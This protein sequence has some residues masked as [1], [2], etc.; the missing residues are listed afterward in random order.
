MITVENFI[1]GQFQSTSTHIDSFNPA[2]G[3]VHALIPNSGELQVEEAVEAADRAFRG[4][5]ELDPEARAKYLLK[6]ADII[7]SRLEEFALAE[8]KDQGKPVSL[9]R[10]MDIPRAVLNFRSFAEAWQHLTESSN[11]LPSRNAVNYT[12]RHPLGVAG[13]ISPWNLP[14]Y[15]LTFKIAPAI[16]SGEQPKQV[17]CKMA[18]L[19]FYTQV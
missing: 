13:L 11:V 8:S 9:A 12:L 18:E 4:W 15:L 3:K 6:I 1:D 5:S 10:S 2:T 19:H 17:K 16:M 14:L 7:E